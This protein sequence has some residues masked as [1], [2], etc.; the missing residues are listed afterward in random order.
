[1]SVNQNPKFAFNNS[2]TISLTY[3]G[4]GGTQTLNADAL[5]AED[6]VTSATGIITGTS[7][8]ITVTL[9]DTTITFSTPQ[10][11]ATTSTPQF[12]RLGLGVAADAGLALS[13]TR[14]IL[15]DGS[16]DE[17]QLRVQGHATQTNALLVLEDSAG[18]DQVTVSNDGAVVLNEEGNAGGD[19]RVEG[20]T[21]ANL[22]F[23]DASDN[24]VY[25]GGSATGK[26]GLHKST[27]AV[28]QSTG[29]AVSNVTPDK[30][31]D[32]NSTSIDEIADVLGTLITF[33]LSRGDLGA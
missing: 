1:M 10:D 28:A 25:F 29:W 3:T 19:L 4:G 7:N 6:F 20:D 14:G 13:T 27:G 33:L 22:L 31:F 23:V 11:I 12:A 32:A 5:D 9:G 30:V 24:A 18:N 15:V 21:E 8:Q 16:S 17:I 2:D 26:V